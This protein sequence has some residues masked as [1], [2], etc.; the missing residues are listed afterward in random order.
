VLTDPE[1]MDMK[2][3]ATRKCWLADVI[4]CVCVMLL[5][6]APVDTREGKGRKDKGK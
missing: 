3:E 2:K 6:S 1:C 4:V 5:R